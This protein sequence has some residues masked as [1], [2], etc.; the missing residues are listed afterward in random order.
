MTISVSKKLS[1]VGAIKT[2]AAG[3]ICLLLFFLCSGCGAIKDVFAADGP[4]Y[5]PNLYAVYNQV[6]LRNSTA[7]D[8]LETV[9]PLNTES[10]SQSTSVVSVNGAIKDGFKQWFLV[11][12]FDEDKLT[13]QRKYIFIEDEKPKVYF[14]EP[15]P[16]GQF[17][18]MIVIDRDTMLEPYATESERR[19]AI[20]DRITEYADADMQELAGENKAVSIAGMMVRQSL[21]AAVNHLKSS[22]VL[23]KQL[24]NAEGMYFPQLTYSQGR[25]QMV[26]D[27]DIATVK[28]RIGSLADDMK[29]E[30]E[31]AKKEAER[32]QRLQQQED[33]GYKGRV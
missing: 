31:E 8:V 14:S 4:P 29:R 1:T 26:I 33:K 3:L 17:D 23:A 16:E 18:C 5:D 13:V 10:L 12:A 32:K 2:A 28:M 30:A 6:Q 22:P 19:I 25:I 7:A 21:S 9:Q 11:F 15:R 27:G 24:D 20:L